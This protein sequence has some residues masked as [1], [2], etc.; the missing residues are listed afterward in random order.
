MNKMLIAVLENES[1][2]AEARVE[3]A[4]RYVTAETARKFALGCAKRA[5]VGVF[6]C[7][8]QNARE[9][10][11]LIGDRA[12]DRPV[13]MGR[14]HE[15]RDEMIRLEEDSATA[16]AA[17]AYGA[18]AAAMDENPYAAA[19][20]AGIAEFYAYVNVDAR[21]MYACEDFY[22]KQADDL[23]CRM[24]YGKPSLWTVERT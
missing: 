20:N 14:W 22:A 18:V 17:D 4:L 10:L 1:F 24:K 7:P 23:L 8:P 11:A 19:H 9:A 16:A 12:E 21:D 6:P 3:F 15:L 5:V 13:D 2:P